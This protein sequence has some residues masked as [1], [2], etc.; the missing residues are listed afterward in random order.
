MSSRPRAL[1]RAELPT[2]DAPP[3]SGGAPR[4][5]E[6]AQD[7][8]REWLEFTDPANPVFMWKKTS[9]DFPA[10]LGGTSA[11]GQTWSQPKVTRI[12]GQDDPVIVM[13]GGYD[14]AEDSDPAGATTMGN[15]VIL[16]N[17]LTGATLKTLGGG[18]D[19]TIARPVAADVTLVDAD[20]DGYVDRGYAVV[21]TVSGAILRT[22]ADAP[23][24]TRLRVRVSDGAV[25]AV[26]EGSE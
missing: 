4:S 7:F 11:L 21:Q 10:P 15:S 6:V 24:G 9:S 18:S 1:R 2:S 3:A 8:P 12:Q 5:R 20:F 25:T 16:L 26:S 13:G 14:P 22:T 19:T 23:A 17:A